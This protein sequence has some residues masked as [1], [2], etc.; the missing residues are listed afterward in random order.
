MIYGA[1]N[2]FNMRLK[3][4]VFLT[5]GLLVPDIGRLPPPPN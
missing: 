1:L 3:A 4:D 2:T 5:Y